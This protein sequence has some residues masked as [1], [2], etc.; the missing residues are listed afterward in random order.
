M[1]FFIGEN[2]GWAVMSEVLWI[3]ICFLDETYVKMFFFHM[4]FGLA[5]RM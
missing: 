4:G 2:K 1:L 5:Y 3:Y